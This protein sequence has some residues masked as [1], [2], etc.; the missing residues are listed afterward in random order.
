MRSTCASE[1]PLIP[2]LDVSAPQFVT[3]RRNLYELR[4]PPSFALRR[5]PIACHNRPAVHRQSISTALKFR[6]A[7]PENIRGASHL[8][9]IRDVGRGLG[10]RTTE[11]FVAVLSL[12][13]RLA[14]DTA[15]NGRRR[16]S[17]SSRACD[18]SDQLFVKRRRHARRNKPSAA[19]RG[20]TLP[21]DTDA[22]ALRR[23][24]ACAVD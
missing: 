14:F 16:P 6:R 10:L 3:R 11:E 20:R 8:R 13:P 2:Y 5:A 12:L 19:L 7:L 23:D 21:S 1:I 4:N 15:G 9:R 17:A 22:L 18:G 24:D